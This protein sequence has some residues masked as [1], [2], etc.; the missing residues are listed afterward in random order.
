MFHQS[1][2]E[3]FVGHLVSHSVSCLMTHP[4]K[5]EE[6]VAQRGKIERDVRKVADDADA[7]ADAAA[8]RNFLASSSAT[9]ATMSY[10]RSNR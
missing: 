9:M 2:I 8:D 6:R 5:R 1:Q 7:D 3:R 10:E 4:R